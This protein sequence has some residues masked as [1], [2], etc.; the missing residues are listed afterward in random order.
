MDIKEFSG[1]IQF[2]SNW[3]LFTCENPRRN[4]FDHPSSWNSA[5]QLGMGRTMQNDTHKNSSSF[6][7]SA[8]KRSLLSN[9]SGSSS[10]GGLGGSIGLNYTPRPSSSTRLKGLNSN[11]AS[12]RNTYNQ[13][14]VQTSLVRH[15][16]VF[17]SLPCSL[18]WEV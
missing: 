7:Q 11:V 17:P 5:A 14:S 13:D 2:Q 1:F 4:T 12:M 16:E 6:Q 15:S 18:E 3:F 9:A 10:L 8:D